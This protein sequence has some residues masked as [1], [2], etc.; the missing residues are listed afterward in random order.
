MNDG[1]SILSE[2]EKIL[3]ERFSKTQ[4]DQPQMPSDAS[5]VRSSDRVERLVLP[6]EMRGK[7]PLTKSKYLVRENPH[8]V[9][10]EREVRKFL[11]RLSPEHEHRVSA[12]MIYEWATGIPIVELQAAEQGRTNPKGTAHTTYRSD[13]RKINK[14]LAH[15]FGKPYSTYIAGRKVPKAYKVKGGYLITRHRPLTLTLWAE[16]TQ[17]VLSP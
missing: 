2:A 11:R 5:A 13:L 9:M 4:R 12:V 15:Y 7:M 14:V 6:D 3:K 17:G 10:W 16:Y 8:L 1:A